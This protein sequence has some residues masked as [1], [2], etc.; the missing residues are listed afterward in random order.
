MKLDWAKIYALSGVT[1]T[2]ALKQQAEIFSKFGMSPTIIA[3]LIACL[4]TG[5]EVAPAPIGIMAASQVPVAIYSLRKV[6]PAYAGNCC[7]VRDSGN[8]L[9]TFGFNANG[10]IDVSLAPTYGDG[11]TFTLASFYDQSGGNH[12][13]SST[14]RPIFKLAQITTQ[15]GYSLPGIDFTSKTLNMVTTDTFVAVGGTNNL[16]VHIIGQTA[17]WS[18]AGTHARAPAVYSSANGPM[19]GYGTAANGLVFGAYMASGET[20][21]YAKQGELLLEDGTPTA[22]RV[23]NLWFNQRGATVAGGADIRKFYTGRVHGVADA[24][25]QR[26]V[27]GNNGAVSQSHNG[28]IFEVVL[29]QNATPMADT[30]AWAI[31]LGQRQFWGALGAANYPTRYYAIG[32]GQSLMQYYATIAS[33]STG[34]LADCANLR[35]FTPAVTTLLNAAGY[36]DR[37][38]L[39]AFGATAYGG[40][41]ALKGAGAGTPDGPGGTSWLSWDGST[42]VKKFWWDQDLDIPGPVLVNWKTQIAAFVGAKYNN[43]AILWDQ[44]QAE[45]ITFSGGEV[46]SVTIANWTRCTP[47]IWANMRATLG[48]AT[49]PIVIQPLGRQQGYDTMMRTLR[50]IQNQFAANDSTVH[51]SA[52]DHDLTRQDGVHLGAGPADPYG[53]DTAATRISKGFIAQF[54]ASV[55]Y[56]GPSV[57][58]AVRSSTTSVDVTIGWAATGSGTDFTPTSGIVGF[59]ITDGGGARTISAAV[60]QSASTIRLTVSGAAFSGSVSVIHNP[61]PSALDRTLMVIDNIGLPLAPCTAIMDII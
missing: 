9:R 10:V 18:S 24:Q 42:L 41:S 55:K 16:A 5:G 43:T 6:N 60:R 48:N 40:S 13:F 31:S 38:L 22:A 47:L 58:S 50:L 20:V 11:V 7:Q 37:E 61:Q 34:L 32:A 54:D 35:I 2:D 15:D 19:L 14:A 56:T 8:T 45:A 23:R 46:G 26:L 59:E 44:G 27:L 39:A 52:D 1:P 21:M 33:A 36:P 4:G 57:I 3:N 29:Y 53:F 17:G 28:M 30:E 25:S 12:H 51:L 49:I